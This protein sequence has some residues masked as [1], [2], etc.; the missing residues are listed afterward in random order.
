MSTFCHFGKRYRHVRQLGCKVGVP[1]LIPI[2]TGYSLPHWCSFAGQSALA[3]VVLDERTVVHGGSCVCL[4]VAPPCTLRC[5]GDEGRRT[6][7]GSFAAPP[8]CVTPAVVGGLAG[9]GRGVQG[10]RKRD[11]L[12]FWPKVYMQ[13]SLGLG[14]I[15]GQNAPYVGHCDPQSSARTCGGVRR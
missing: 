10:S 6:G 7:D 11:A 14:L 8:A 12:A 13:P 2:H 1:H 15:S 4:F 5:G 9:Y 3:L